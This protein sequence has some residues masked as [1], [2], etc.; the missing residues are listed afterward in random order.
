M[1]DRVP[2]GRGG[3]KPMEILPAIFEA[4]SPF[5]KIGE[6]VTMIEEYVNY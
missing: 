6:E 5:R 4:G 1:K 2:S 3:F